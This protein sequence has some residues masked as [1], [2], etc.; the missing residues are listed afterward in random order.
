MQSVDCLTDVEATVCA[1]ASRAL[2]YI[3]VLFTTSH[4]G[5]FTEMCSEESAS[6][7][8]NEATSEWSAVY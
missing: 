1:G 6:R 3:E 5:R 2:M 8:I 7:Y 4:N